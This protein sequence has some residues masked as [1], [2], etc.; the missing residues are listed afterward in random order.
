MNS[1]RITLTEHYQKADRIMLGVLWLMFVYALGLA[2]WHGTWG[3]ALLV[4]GGT[5]GCMHLLH[6]L[7]GG[8]RLLRCL[9]GAAFMVMAALHINQSNGLLEMHFGIFVL[10]AILVYYRDW[11]P[12]VVAAAVIA[13]HHLSFF[14]LQQQGSD[15]HLIEHG[16]WPIVFLH[17]FYVVLETA[18]LVYLAR[19]TYGE[20]LESA[21]LT[22]T[23]TLMTQQ[24]DAVDLRLRSPLAGKAADRF[25]AF[26]DQLDELIH[27]VVRD[28]Q[29]LGNMSEQL[30]QA[31]HHLRQGATR[32][33]AETQYMSTAMLQMATAIDEVAG[34]ADQASQSAKAANQQ[35]VDGSRSVNHI[36]TEI[37]KLASHIDGTDRDVQDLA[38]QA[39]QIGQVVEV[40]RSIADQTNLLAL[41]AAIE[42]AR[43]G[44]QG[45]GFAVVADE[46]RNLAQK[47]A[48][49]TAEIQ[50]IISR[51]QQGSRQAA[52]AMQESRDSVQR[53]VSDTQNTADLL[54]AVATGI[55]SISQMNELIASAT[56]Q[57]AA[58]SNEVREHLI[59]VQQVAE[60]NVDDA[61]AL[62][63]NSRELAQLAERLTRMSQRFTVSG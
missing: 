21:A 35:A 23:V 36:R 20:A 17:A 46:V 31:T 5:L 15:V 25:N 63:D 55:G 18:L 51:L 47:T 1:P 62:N 28:T 2:A 52:G 58:V 10:L 34:H 13:V 24:A 57:Q 56:H 19:Q 53:C 41:N 16:S 59:S 33:Q 22:Q 60:Q 49:S 39:E 14:A 61:G 9:I 50:G 6:S 32:Q 11:L 30:A 29:G 45:R 7:I 12:I 8:R 42:A 37:G 48:L 44:D 3:Q 38:S 43:A 26:L 4:G 40:I 54:G 27:E